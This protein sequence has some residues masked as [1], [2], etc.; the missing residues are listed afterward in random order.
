MPVIDSNLTAPT[1]S[2]HRNLFFAVEHQRVFIVHDCQSRAVDL[3]GHGLPSVVAVERQVV[4]GPDIFPLPLPGGGIEGRRRF[5]VRQ[6]LRN[7]WPSAPATNAVL[8]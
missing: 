8:A 4:I 5:E 3:G 7:A 1:I 6:T 2:F